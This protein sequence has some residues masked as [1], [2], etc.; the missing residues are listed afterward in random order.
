MRRLAIVAVMA[1]AGCATQVMQGYVG[2]D[3]TDVVLE[4][5]PPTGTMDM[6]DGRRAF[7]WRMDSVYSMPGTTY[8]SGNTYGN[9]T[10]GTFN[11]VGGGIYSQSC[12]YTLFGQKNPRGSY[13]VVGF[14]PPPLECE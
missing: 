13:T 12:V 8:Y 7:Q 6:P 14:H 2:K 1:V 9:T 5:G 4:R 3:I 11:T 10:Y